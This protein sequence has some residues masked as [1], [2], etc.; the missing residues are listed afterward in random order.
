MARY[1]RV[2][3]PASEII[4]DRMAWLWHPLVGVS[5]LYA[6]GVPATMGNTIQN[7][8]MNLFANGGRPTGIINIPGPI[9]QPMA[10]ALKEQWQTAYTG[11]NI[12]KTGILTEGMTFQPV[13]AMTALNMQLTEQLKLAREDVALAFHYPIWKLAGSMPPYT[14]PDQ[15]QT[16]YYIDC[17]QIHIEQIEKCLKDGLELPLDLWA[18]FDLEAL[19]RMDTEALYASNNAAKGWMKLDEQ[20]YRANLPPLTTGGDTVYL[21]HQDYSVEALAKRDAK[22]DPFANTDAQGNPTKPAP[23]PMPSPEPKA[24]RES[25]IEDLSLMRDALAF[26]IRKHVSAA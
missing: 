4:H 2:V 5:P 24:A 21:Q 15:A 17:L 25:S 12:G 19:M 3:I 1:G 16:Q 11:T 18:E 20:R 14:K 7:N 8:S 26:R 23:A 6:C 22:P 13:E 9:T 10:D